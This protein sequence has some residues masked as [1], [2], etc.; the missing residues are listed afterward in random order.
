MKKSC[1][2]VLMNL[3]LL[4]LIGGETRAQ[5]T[6]QKLGY[7]AQEKL[8]ILHADD[9]GL[10]HSVNIATL[11][12]MQKGLVNSASIMVPCPWFPEIAAHVRQNPN[13]DFGLHLT[14]TSEWQFLRWRSIASIDS[15]KGLL[16]KEGFMWRSVLETVTHAT[17]AEVETELRA[18]IERALAF[19]IKPTHLDTHMGTLYARKDYFEVYAKL[20]KEYGIPVMA[21]RPTPELLEV[22]QQS[23]VTPAMMNKLEADGYVLLDYLVTNVP[24]KGYAERK[25]SWHDCLRNLKPGVTEII[26]HLSGNDEEAKATMGETADY[27]SLWRNADFRT[28]TNDDTRAL[29]KQLGIKQT[30]WRE[31]GKLAWKGQ[32]G[33]K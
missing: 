6:A 13:L 9:V 31:L 5:T 32:A 8:L 22:N 33:T 23:P 7:G 1:I 19:G 14:L 16:D 24:G 20:G 28:F 4:L 15:V 2:A 17:P 3:V 11:E 18:Q 27:G 26:V 29:M 10:A 21:I 12:A 25:K 30:T